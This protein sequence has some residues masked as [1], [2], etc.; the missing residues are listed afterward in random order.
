[1]C[2]TVFMHLSIQH[3]LCCKSTKRLSNVELGGFFS[4]SSGLYPIGKISPNLK[5]VGFSPL[6]RRLTSFTRSLYL[7]DFGYSSSI[8][9][10]ILSSSYLGLRPISHAT[11]DIPYL[12]IYKLS[13][14]G[15]L[16]NSKIVVGVR[17]RI[18]PSPNGGI[19][20][21]ATNNDM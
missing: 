11:C 10:I 16:S 19:A 15:K 1:M 17:F 9:T 7:N 3:P 14:M 2:T 8:P 4:C 18:L 12:I 13:M 20:Q 5:L 6:H 21:S